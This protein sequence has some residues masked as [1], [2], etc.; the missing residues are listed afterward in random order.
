MKKK[1]LIALFLLLASV[2]SADNG[3]VVKFIQTNEQTVADTTDETTLFG[4][5]QGSPTIDGYYFMGGN[6]G[7]LIRVHLEG[8]IGTAVLLPSLRIRVKMGG[9]TFMDS[10]A[11]TVLSISGDRRFALDARFVVR[12]TNSPADVAGFGMFTYSTGVTGTGALELS[13]SVNSVD[14]TLSQEIEVTAQW[15]TA[16]ASNTITTHM[17][18]IELLAY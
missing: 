17:A 12:D 8:T 14:L 10:T 16:S 2:S 1:L 6:P 7:Q 3:V 15:G 5:G 4:A 11:T 18:T 13:G 9:V